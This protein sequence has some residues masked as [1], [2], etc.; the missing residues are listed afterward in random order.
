MNISSGL[1]VRKLVGKG[2]VVYFPGIP[3][4]GPLPRMEPYFTIDNRFWKRPANWE[5]L[6]GEIRWAANAEMPVDI[7]GPEFLAA[8]LVWQP[9]KRREMVHLVNYDAKNTPSISGIDLVCRPPVS[10]TAKSVK[11]YGLDHNATVDLSFKIQPHAA[12]FTVP[13]MKTYALIV[14]GW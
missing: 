2:R 5:E 12:S 1:P 6:I 11:L 9:E 8:N 14:I 10:E 3:F 7:S 13:E 4:D